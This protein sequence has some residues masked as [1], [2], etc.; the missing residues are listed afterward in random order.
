MRGRGLFSRHLT[1]LLLMTVAVGLAQSDWA[2]A[3]MLSPAHAALRCPM[4]GQG[5]P[6]PSAGRTP[7]PTH[8]QSCPM[9]GMCGGM[10]AQMLQAPQPQVR[11]VLPGFSPAAAVVTDSVAAHRMPPPQGPPRLVVA[12]PAAHVYLTTLRLRI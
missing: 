4:A 10:P 6:G 11:L 9:L 3:T 7:M 12:L 2:C 1:V 8:R 5:A